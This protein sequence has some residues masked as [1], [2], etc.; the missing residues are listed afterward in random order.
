MNPE[1]RVRTFAK[2]LL[3]SAQLMFCWM[4]DPR[5]EQIISCFCRI[6][7]SLIFAWFVWQF[8][9][10]VC[11]KGKIHFY[12]RTFFI[13]AAPNVLW[14][15]GG[16]MRLSKKPTKSPPPHM[17][18]HETPGA[19]RPIGPYSQ[20]VSSGGFVYCSGSSAIQTKT[21]EI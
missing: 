21:N 7:L 16:A 10:V 8:D 15:Y 2:T 20:A 19:P 13:R 6:H 12:S 1:S 5:C 9:V 11:N 17:N 18:K 14:L 4:K 3:I